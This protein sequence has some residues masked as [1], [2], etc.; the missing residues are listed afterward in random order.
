MISEDKHIDCVFLMR[1]CCVNEAAGCRGVSACILFDY[2][3]G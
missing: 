3:V 2:W 1:I